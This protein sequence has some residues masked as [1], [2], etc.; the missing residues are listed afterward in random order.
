MKKKI[1]FVTLL[2]LI[3]SCVSV[4]AAPDTILPADVVNSTDGILTITNPSTT[5]ISSYD[6]THN[7]AGSAASGA[8]I[9]IYTLNDGVY[10]LLHKDGTPVTFTSGASGMFI[11]PVKLQYGRNDIIIRAEINGNVQYAARTITVLSPN[12]LNLFKGFKLF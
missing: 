6:K 2:V 9:S 11:T 1:L 8:V 5:S 12:L 3:F 7:I 4:F 10:T